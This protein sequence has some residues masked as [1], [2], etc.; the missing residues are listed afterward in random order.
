[1]LPVRWSFVGA[2]GLL[3]LAACS[4]PK[5]PSAQ[6]S[7]TAAPALQVEQP[8]PLPAPPIAPSDPRA[9]AIN[10]ASWPPPGGDPQAKAA[11]LTRAEVLL[12]RARFS[13]GVIDG[14]EG[15]NL[16]TALLAFQQAK[17]LPPTGVLDLATWSTLTKADGA[18]A[19]VGY[20]IR[21]EDVK[22]PFVPVIPTEFRDMAKLDA[23]GFT[24]PLEAL[25][26]KFHMDEGLLSAL[27]PGV[28]FGRPGVTILVAQPALETLP[29]PVAAIEV[30][31]S[32][33]QVRAFAPDGTLLAAYPATVGS[34]ERPAPLGTFKVKKVTLDPFYTYDPKRLTFGDKS[35]GKFSIRP[36]PNNPVGAVWID[37]DLPTYGIHGAPEPKLVG[38]VASHGCVRLTNWDVRQLASAVKPGV[39]VTFVGAE[40]PAGTQVAVSSASAASP[41]PPD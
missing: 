41:A 17:G 8:P 13:P 18:P 31:K 12:D 28:D 39:T 36:G 2:A 26:E 22:G 16:Q 24:S 32:G 27:N 9:I 11:A 5:S 7:D 3:I 15:G 14:Q 10:Q 4:G 23:L 21:P 19:I 6:R 40:R 20:V 35:A 1:M 34:T 33:R 25:A 30:D 38:K 29:A 37:L